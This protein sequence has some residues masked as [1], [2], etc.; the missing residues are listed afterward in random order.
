MAPDVTEVSYDGDLRLRLTFEDRLTATV[1][2]APHIKS[3]DGLCRELRDPAYFSQARVDRDL[4][5][6][7]WP[8][9]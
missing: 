2:F 4:H 8:N 7:V 9:G 3:R 5:M 1:D 6:I